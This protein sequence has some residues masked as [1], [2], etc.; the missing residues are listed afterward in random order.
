MN[1]TASAYA[2][3]DS[4]PAAQTDAYAT[5]SAD[6]LLLGPSSGYATAAPL[7][8]AASPYTVT[9]QSN[10]SVFCPLDLRLTSWKGPIFA[11][12]NNEPAKPRPA[13]PESAGLLAAPAQRA[14]VA[15]AAAAGYVF[16]VRNPGTDVDWN[17]ELQ[18]L[19]EA[20]EC[21][22]KY[23]RLA[24]LTRDFNYCAETFG[25]IVISELAV[26][27]ALKTIK[28]ASNA[29]GQAGGQK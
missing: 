25:K 18:E 26:P 24:A 1:Q 10:F 22:E 11:S 16:P 9:G 7:A 6:E 21:S 17:G 2:A 15:A 13:A 19:L 28:P 5:V 3:S 4:L 27:Y 29:G 14:A 23:R 8:E 12:M 20:P